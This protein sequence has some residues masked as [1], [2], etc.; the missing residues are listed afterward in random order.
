MSKIK[1]RGKPPKNAVARLNLF[2]LRTILGHVQPQDDALWIFSNMVGGF[3]SIVI[4]VIRLEASLRVYYLI[5]RTLLGAI[6]RP[7]DRPIDR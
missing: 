1:F 7:A 3:C 4:K 5:L 6:D 2:F